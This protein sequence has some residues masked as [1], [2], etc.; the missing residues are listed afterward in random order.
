MKF[1]WATCDRFKDDPVADFSIRIIDSHSKN[2]HQYNI[3]SASKFTVLIVCDI[4]MDYTGRDVIIDHKNK[5]SS[6]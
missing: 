5:G 1:F 2:G 6:V 3:P 4:S